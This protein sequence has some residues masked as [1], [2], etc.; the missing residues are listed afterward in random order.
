M[1]NDGCILVAATGNKYGR[2]KM[3]FPAAYKNV[4]SVTGHLSDGRPNPVSN[5][6]ENVSVALPSDERFFSDNQAAL[7]S[8]TSAAAAQLSG[9]LA[10]TYKVLPFPKTSAISSLLKKLQVIS[11]K[12]K[13]TNIETPIFNATTI[14]Q[15][16]KQLL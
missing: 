7:S 11:I 5:F 10:C 1:V 6:W 9:I 3:F 8:Q 4:I 2:N 12:Y 15:L 14:Y 16:L 13:E